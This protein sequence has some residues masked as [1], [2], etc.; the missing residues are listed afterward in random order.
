MLQKSDE[1]RSIPWTPIDCQTSSGTR[2]LYIK[3]VFSVL[4]YTVFATDFENLWVEDMT[5]MVCNEKYDGS[6]MQNFKP[7]FRSE[8]SLEIGTYLQGHRKTCK[9]VM[10]KK[11]GELILSIKFDYSLTSI[12]WDFNMKTIPKLLGDKAPLGYAESVFYMHVVAPLRWKTTDAEAP[13]WK[14]LCER[15]MKTLS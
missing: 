8:V 4:K 14:T 3:S 1:L 13:N 11:N 6:Y 12:E 9:Y 7:K 5:P 15:K 2:K 10:E